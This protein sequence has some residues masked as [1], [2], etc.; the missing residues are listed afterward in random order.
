MFGNKAVIAQIKIVLLAFVRSKCGF[1]AQC[2]C[3]CI[4]ANGMNIQRFCGITVQL[5]TVI[6]FDIGS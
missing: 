3:D 5:Y 2:K 6:S 1:W 4:I